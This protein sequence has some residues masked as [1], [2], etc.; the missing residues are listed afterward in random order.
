MKLVGLAVAALLTLVSCAKKESQ[1]EPK[2]ALVESKTVLTSF[3]PMYIIA[4]NLANGVVGIEVKNMTKPQT[5]CLHDY[6]ITPDDMKMLSTASVFVVNG[7]GMESFLDKV[8][9]EH[10]TMA[11]V[12]ASTG[13]PLISGGEEGDNPHLWVS[14]TNCMAQ[15]KNVCEGLVKADP[16][17]EKQYRANAE[18]Y[19][20]KLDSLK[21]RMHAG[22]DTLKSRNIITFHE[23]FPYF[24]QEFN[25]NI[26]SVIEREPGSEPSAGELAETV[27]IVKKH[28]VKALFAE[29][30]Y[31]AKA[32]ET[33]AR[34]TGAKLFTLD[35]VVSGPDSLDA[36]IQIM[37]KNLTTLVKALR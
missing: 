12:Q 27:E 16:A 36:Y 3:Y 15:V 8:I 25:L 26:A 21:T 2:A 28:S 1:A 29:P 18:T 30:Q 7:A 22:I 31:P 13:I 4:K 23:A 35:P 10:P 20:A 5:G 19:L 37:D 11:V 6:S 33:I 32:A 14:V 9:A 24:A 17:N 34:E